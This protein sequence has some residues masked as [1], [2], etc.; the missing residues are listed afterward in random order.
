MELLNYLKYI[1]PLT[2]VFDTVVSVFLIRKGLKNKI[3]RLYLLAL[4]TLV[5]WEVFFWLGI[6]THYDIFTDSIIDRLAFLFGLVSQYFL[7]EFLIQYIQ[8]N[9]KI[10]SLLRIAVMLVVLLLLTAGV[11]ERQYIGIEVYSYYLGHESYSSTILAIYYIVS[12]TIC[13]VCFYLSYLIKFT[14]VSPIEVAKRKL[15]RNS[16]IVSL[17][18]TLAPLSVIPLSVLL[19]PTHN[20]KEVLASEWYITCIVL[21]AILS[22]I[23]TATTAY[24]L[25]RYRLFDVTIKLKRSFLVSICIVIIVFLM[26]VLNET[27]LVELATVERLVALTV[28]LL[29]MCFLTIWCSQKIGAGE[30]ISFALSEPLL[31]NITLQDLIKKL[32]TYIQSEFEIKVHGIYLLDY[33]SKHFS[34]SNTGEVIKLTSELLHTLKHGLIVKKDLPRQFQMGQIIV[35]LLS[36][37]YLVAFL[38]LEKEGDADLQTALQPYAGLIYQV[39]FL[40][41]LNT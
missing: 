3:V 25:T 28:L 21:S 26:L 5:L 11:G 38:V 18:I 39:Q 13:I 7:M 37:G 20:L 8:Y 30:P 1:L 27:L 2:I 16:I 32:N 4:G 23:W 17:T 12:I 41:Y 31:P 9:K 29:C 19:F 15:V 22:S 33:S 35:P 34:N 14:E 24:A 36:N 10:V 6:F 40:N